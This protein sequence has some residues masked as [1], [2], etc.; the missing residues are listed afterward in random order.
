MPRYLT[1][2]DIYAF[3]HVYSFLELELISKDPV[4]K[5]RCILNVC[6]TNKT[7]SKFF[8]TL[9]FLKLNPGKGGFFWGGLSLY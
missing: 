8:V 3:V 6:K 4:N 5:I 9:H 1:M 7:R 2:Y